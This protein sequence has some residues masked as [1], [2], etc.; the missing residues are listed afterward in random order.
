MHSSRGKEVRAHALAS[1]A[2]VNSDTTK[3]PR[4][5][6]VVDIDGH[7]QS[8]C[9]RGPARR[10]GSHV[11][12]IDPPDV[13]ICIYFL[14]PLNHAIISALQRK[15]HKQPGNFAWDSVTV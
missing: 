15:Y 4:V 2:F 7:Q 3:S 10:I 8:P 13:E 6:V 11:H 1:I 5:V 12:A 9:L 14:L